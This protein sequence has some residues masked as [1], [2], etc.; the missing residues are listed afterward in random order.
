[1]VC[2]LRLAVP[3]L[4]GRHQAFGFLDV[5]VWG[6]PGSACAKH[7]KRRM[8]IAFSGPLQHRSFERKDG[9]TGQAL[10]IPAATVQFPPMA[11]R[12]DHD[13]LL[14]DTTAPVDSDGEVRVRVGEDDIAF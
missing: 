1:Q 3:G 12:D 11:P 13:P 2:N 9:T 7:L 6:A 14:D 8:T 4:A 10:G 5:A